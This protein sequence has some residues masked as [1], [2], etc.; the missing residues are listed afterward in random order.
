MKRLMIAV[1]ITL[2]LSTVTLSAE[3]ECTE[4]SGIILTLSILWGSISGADTHDF[5]LWW[6]GGPTCMDGGAI[7]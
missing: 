7:Y 6:Y 1:A 3:S 4:G 5:A 2:A